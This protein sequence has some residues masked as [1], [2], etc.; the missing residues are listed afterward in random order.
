MWV[1]IGDEWAVWNVYEI[2]WSIPREDG[3]IDPLQ[4]YQLHHIPTNSRQNMMR[5]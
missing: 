4:D 5:D 3:K 1:S 2:F